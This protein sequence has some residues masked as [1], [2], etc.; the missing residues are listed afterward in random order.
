MAVVLVLAAVVPGWAQP[1]LQADLSRLVVVGDSL[2]AAFQNGALL[3]TQQVNGYAALVARQA[4]VDLALPLIGDPGIPNVLTLVD[5][6]PPPVVVPITGASVGRVDPL[7]Q[8]RNLAVP[9][10]TVQ[11]ALSA[12]PNTPIDRLTDLVLGLPGLLPEVVFGV[13]GVS[14]SQVEWAEQLAPTTVLVWLGNNDALG[15]ALAGDPAVLTPVADFETAYREVLG[16]LAATG[17]TLVV[18][19]IPDVSAIAFLTPAED[20]LALVAETTGLPAAVVEALLGITA[21]DRV[22]PDAFALIPGIL[23]NPLSGPLPGHV[24]VTAAEAATIEATTA[25]Y[26]TVI[27]ATAVTHGAALVDVNALVAR[28]RDR[29]IVVGGQRLSTAFLGGLFSL[30]GVHP[31]NTGYAVIAA[32]FVEVLNREFAAGLPHINVRQ[33]QKDDPLVLPG[34]GHPASAFGHPAPDAAAR[35]RAVLGRRP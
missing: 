23:G 26:N 29:G 1:R 5:P 19:N 8:T 25:A 20:V 12:R 16:R 2:S 4:G 32:E 18:A 11:D 13:S 14:L 9:G 34:V 6:G 28:A 27:A 10:A 17:A 3:G 21:G 33:I 7:T 35:L 22:T 24:V 30:D 15:A 31:T